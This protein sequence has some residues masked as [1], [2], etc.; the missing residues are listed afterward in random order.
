MRANRYRTWAVLL[1][2]LALTA[3]MIGAAYAY[4]SNKSGTVT[5]TL[6]PATQAD[7]TIEVGEDLVVNVGNPQYPVYVRAAILIT[8][9]KE[10]AIYATLPVQGT[11]YVLDWDNTNW[12]QGADGFYYHREAV[13]SG[14]LKLIESLQQTNSANIPEGYS[15]HAEVFVQ[16]I[17]AVGYTDVGNQPA[18]TN[19]WGIDVASDGSLI[20]TGAIGGD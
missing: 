4:L 15:L 11:D 2:L 16:T 12:F 19:A 20:D 14:S 13:A 3:A 17:Q 10:G 8:W 5:N 18:V 9:A 7:P 6:T 1:L